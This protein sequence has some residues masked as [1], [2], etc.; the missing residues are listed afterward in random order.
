MRRMYATAAVMSIALLDAHAGE[1]AGRW[2]APDDPT[3]K[4][5]VAAEKMWAE[6]GCGPAA[7][8]LEG[9]IADD[10][11]GTSTKGGR[12]PKAKA[13]GAGKNRNCELGKV[14]VRFFGDSVAIAYGRESSMSK[15]KDGSER[16]RCLVWTDTWLQRD[17]KWKIVSAQDN[18]TSCEQSDP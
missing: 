10:F 11:Q 16:K 3:V 4:S 2:G 1:S 17:G 9:F 15:T 12:Y 5:I 7:P 18:E 14:N 6:S 8:A 13:L